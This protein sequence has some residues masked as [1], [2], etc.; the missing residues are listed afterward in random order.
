MEKDDNLRKPSLFLDNP[1]VKVDGDLERAIKNLNKRFTNYKTLK[2]L[3]LRKNY[4]T[5]K[6]RKRFKRRIA[7]GK[8]K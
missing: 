6:Q 1:E 8:F 4:V 7:N 5:T 3:K 2:L